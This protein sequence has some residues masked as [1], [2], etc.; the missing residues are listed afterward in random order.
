MNPFD[1]FDPARDERA[2][3]DEPIE[4]ALRDSLAAHAR[5]GPDPDALTQRILAAVDGPSR[6]PSPDHPSRG[7]WRTWG[8]PLVAAASVAAIVGGVVALSR[9]HPSSDHPQAATAAPSISAAP[10][11]NPSRP[12]TPS[13][14]IVVAPPTSRT[15]APSATSSTPSDTSTLHSV[16]VVD[17][18]FT[19]TNTGFAL[20]SANCITTTG[21]C[22]A[23]E[24]TTNGITWT[25]HDDTPFDVPGIS[26]GCPAAS[27]VDHIRFATD[28]IGYVFGPD[29]LF[30][31][32]DGAQHWKQLSGGADALETLDHNVIRVSTHTEGCPPDCSYTVQTAAI[33][34]DSWTTVSM[35]G[36][37]PNGDAVTLSRGRPNAY[38]LVGQN[39][40]GGA[41]GRSTLYRSTD[42]GAS[43]IRSGE[44]C[45]QYSG[46]VDSY[47]VSAGVGDDVSVLCRPRSSSAPW[48]VATSTNGGASFGVGSGRIAFGAVTQTGAS[49]QSVLAG[50]PGTVLA[51]AGAGVSIST[52]GGT[53]WQSAGDVTGRI[54]FVGFESATVGRAVS[55]DGRVIWTTYDAGQSWTRTSLG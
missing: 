12:A 17:L 40:A 46:E 5:R 9:Y 19:G 50:D 4:A 38:L 7:P 45:P 16:K 2:R 6:L 44:P 18:T 23:L 25:S 30:M 14:G 47:G 11:P 39:P 28:Q 3:P 15:H 29:A 20:E 49:S 32:T 51:V 41:E 35:P 10:T 37:A 21:R 48:S 52:D 42:D 1:P 26:T 8:L 43:W 36:G 24:T 33:G 55:T 13:K 31:T 54:G 22:T 27:C 34:S 53:S